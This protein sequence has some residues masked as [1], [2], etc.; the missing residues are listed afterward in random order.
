MAPMSIARI[1]ISGKSIPV[2]KRILIERPFSRL[3]HFQLDSLGERPRIL[4]VGP[5]SGM[6]MAILHD[7]IIGMLPGHDVYCLTWRNA[8]EVPLEAGPFGLD[9]NIADVLQAM[10]HLGRSTHLIGLCQSALPT[11][12]AT[13]ILAGDQDSPISLTLIGGKLDTRINPTRIDAIARGH[14]REWFDEYAIT[15][16]SSLRPGRGRRIYSGNAEW[17][18]LSTYLLRHCASGGELLSKILYDDGADPFGHPF[19][20]LFFSVVDVPAEFFLDMI[21]RVFHKA[22]LAEGRFAWRGMRI[23]PE[24]ITSTSLLTVEGEADD[25]SGLGQTRVAHDLCSR[26]PIERRDHFL[27][28]KTGHLGLIHGT[29]WR[30]EVL[31]RISRFIEKN[32]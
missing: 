19:L 25:I 14:S 3:I 7:M 8:A 32:G 11:L 9:D 12:A 18:M 1:S 21:S 6:G 2:Q 31:P 28:P 30:S 5:L 20:E 29:V 16:V 22:M 23:A 15:T 26:I 27:C 13:A 17:L 24:T 10:R 4:L